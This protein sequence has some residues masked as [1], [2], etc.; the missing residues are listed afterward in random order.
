MS[1]KTILIVGGDIRQIYCGRK[2][3]RLFDVYYKGFENADISEEI[4]DGTKC[5][6]AIL[7][8]PPPTETG[9][10]FTPLGDEKIYTA[11]IARY[12]AD[13]AVIFTGINPEK[14]AEFFPSCKVVSYTAQEEF[15]LK[16]AISTAEGAVKIALEKLSVTLNGLPVLVVGMGRIGTAL[17]SILKGFGADITAAVR[18]GRGMAKAALLGVKSI[19]TEEITGEYALVFNTAPNL[20]FTG[21]IIEKFPEDTL[22]IELASKPGGF[23]LDYAESINRKIIQAQGLP[24]KKAPIT[25]GYDLA[26]TIIPII[27]RK[28]KCL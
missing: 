14:T 3:S 21:E 23:D 5:G 15:A 22:F 20:V 9:E 17:V 12:L 19:S 28:G 1:D 6:F 11:D 26:D 7:P 4:P 10:I 13:D 18:N 2:L 8:V 16:N 27:N 25:A 24:A